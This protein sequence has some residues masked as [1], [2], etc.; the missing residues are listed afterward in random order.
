MSERRSY[1]ENGTETTKIVVLH[2][3]CDFTA[4]FQFCACQTNLSD[5]QQTMLLRVQEQTKGTVQ[6][7]RT[8]P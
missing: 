7:V 2:V 4:H 1:K 3:S 5:T 8:S 6:G